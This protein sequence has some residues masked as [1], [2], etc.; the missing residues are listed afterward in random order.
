MEDQERS[1]TYVDLTMI[2]CGCNFCVRCV[3]YEH[4]IHKLAS[5]AFIQPSQVFSN[6]I[7]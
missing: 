5:Y 2:L 1:D 4:D 3:C 6:P 7:Q